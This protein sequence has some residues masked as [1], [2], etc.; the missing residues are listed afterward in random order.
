[1][2]VELE[3]GP[4]DAVT[5]SIEHLTVLA[6]LQRLP[7]PQRI[8]AVPYSLISPASGTSRQPTCWAPPGARSLPGSIG[9][10]DAWPGWSSG[11]APPMG[12]EHRHL[13]GFMAGSLNTR[14]ATR[15]TPTCC[16]VIVAGPPWAETAEAGRGGNTPGDRPCRPCG[17]AF[18]SRSSSPPPN[19]PGRIGRSALDQ[20]SWGRGTRR[21]PDPPGGRSCPGGATG[22]K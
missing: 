18:G 15:S 2:P 22:T 8:C 21:N 17:N 5:T 13:H 16:P 20:R 12:N 19:A 3:I 11:R 14:A 9:A 6:A 7:E 4:D 1:V 10:G